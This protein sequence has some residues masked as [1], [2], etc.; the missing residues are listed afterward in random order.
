MN[1]IKIIGKVNIDKIKEELESLKISAQFSLQGKSKDDF[2]SSTSYDYSLRTDEGEFVCPLY[3]LPYTNSVL[4]EYSMFRTRVM[5]MIKGTAYGIHVDNT[6][7]I[8]I[9]LETNENC[10]FIIDDVVYRMPADGS[11][12]FAYTTKPHTAINDNTNRF[13][14]T[15]IVG[16]INV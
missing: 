12:Y 4:K 9:P 10:L 1:D 14:R 13:I 16:N 2:D 11:V 7:R 3:D 5:K 15:H 6:P 8:H